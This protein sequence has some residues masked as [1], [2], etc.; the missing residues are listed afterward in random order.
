MLLRHGSR[1]IMKSVTILSLLRT[2]VLYQLR[3][4][5]YLV[6]KISRNT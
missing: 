3:D 5:L 6:D 4:Y 1:N 2:K